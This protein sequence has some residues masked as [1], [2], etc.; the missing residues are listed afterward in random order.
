MPARLAVLKI[1]LKS[2]VS[3]GLPLYKNRAPLTHPE[4]TL[5]QVLIPLHFNSPRIN[6]Y[7]KLGGGAPLPSRKVLQL[8]TPNSQPIRPF[9]TRYSTLATHHSL[10]LRELEGS[11]ATIPFRITSFADPH[12]L[13]PIESNLYKKPGRGRVTAPL[14]ALV[15]ILLRT[16][17]HWQKTDHQSFQYL[18]HSLRKTPGVGAPLCLPYL[19]TSLRHYLIFSSASAIPTNLSAP[20]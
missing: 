6:T 20:P 9:L 12:L 7:K 17:L 3:P 19:L 2:S 18:P 1:P 16:L 15:F 11:F 13:T 10:A 4:S 5:L 8:V 14:A